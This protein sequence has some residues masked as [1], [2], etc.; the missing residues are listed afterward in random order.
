MSWEDVAKEAEENLKRFIDKRSLE[1]KAEVDLLFNSRI[2]ITVHNRDQFYK[3]VKHCNKTY[4]HGSHCWTV[5]GR[6]LKYIDSVKKSYNPPAVKEWVIKK[7]NQ[8]LSYLLSL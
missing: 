5:R 8:N 6:I 4:G 7:P 1:V 3:L 2:F